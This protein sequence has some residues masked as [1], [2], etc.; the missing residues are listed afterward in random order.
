MRDGRRQ[1]VVDGRRRDARRGEAAARGDF[2]VLVVLR[3]RATVD[4]DDHRHTGLVFRQ[5]QVELVA[6]AKVLDAGDVRDVG[7]H[8]DRGQVRGRERQ[9]RVEK[10][11]AR[12]IDS[13]LVQGTGPCTGTYLLRGPV[14][15]TL[16]G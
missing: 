12:I 4:P 13:A 14:P 9:G 6:I 10:Q 7:D 2:E 16:A 15:C 3:Q 5:V 11:H 1:A 8:L